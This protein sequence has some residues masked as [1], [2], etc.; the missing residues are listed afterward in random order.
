MRTRFLDDGRAKTI[1]DVIL[2]PD[3]Q[4]KAARDRFANLDERE[5]SKLLA[6]L[7]TL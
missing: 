5:K 3:G 6:F 2:A 7:N 1:Q 4:G